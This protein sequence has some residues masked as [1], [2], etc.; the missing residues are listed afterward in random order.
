MNTG[1]AHGLD[2]NAKE[3]GGRER[4]AH[5]DFLIH[6]MSILWPYRSMC[7]ALLR[8]LPVSSSAIAA[9]RKMLDD[10][11]SILRNEQDMVCALSERVFRRTSNFAPWDDAGKIRNIRELEEIFAYAADCMRKIGAAIAEAQVRALGYLGEAAIACASSVPS[12]AEASREEPARPPQH[13][14]DG[15]DGSASR[16]PFQGRVHTGMEAAA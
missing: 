1:S 6:S 9:N 4:E 11:A 13:K 12:A 16:V 10:I 8:T 2:S 15:A 7:H 14:N 3:T 5:P